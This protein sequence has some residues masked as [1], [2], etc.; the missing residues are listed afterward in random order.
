MSKIFASFIKRKYCC[1]TLANWLKCRT[2]SCQNCWKKRLIRGIC[3]LASNKLSFGY[4]HHIDDSS[5]RIGRYARNYQ[6][7]QITNKMREITHDFKI[8]GVPVY[9]TENLLLER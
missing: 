7:A 2:I 5:I 3:N 6:L 4:I 8:S 9:F 1:F